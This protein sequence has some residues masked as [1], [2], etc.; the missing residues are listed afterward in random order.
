MTDFNPRP[1]S[2]VPASADATQMLLAL[3]LELAGKRA[4]R[5]SR[6]GGGRLGLRILS[7]VL[8]LGLFAAALGGMWYLQSVALQ[9]GASP[10]KA[11]APAE[12]SP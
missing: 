10:G 3:E 4:M 9:R 7:V 2:G 5:L 8:L 11:K 12:Q 6:G 1:E